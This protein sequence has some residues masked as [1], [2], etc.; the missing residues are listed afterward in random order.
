VRRADN[1]TNNMCLNLLEP[2]WPVQELLYLYAGDVNARIPTAYTYQ[3]V[4]CEQFSGSCVTSYC[5]LSAEQ[6]KV[7]FPNTL[8]NFA[9]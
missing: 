3:N 5:S 6:Y 4:F 2:S 8:V 1:L 9:V 7:L